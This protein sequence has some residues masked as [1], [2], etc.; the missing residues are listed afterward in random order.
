MLSLEEYEKYKEN[1]QQEK[2]YDIQSL[3]SVGETIQYQE[4]Q[5]NMD[6]ALNLGK[7]VYNGFMSVPRGVLRGVQWLRDMNEAQLNEDHPERMQ[8]DEG[9]R[10]LLDNAADA[11]MFQPYKVQAE[12]GAGQFVYDLAQGAGQLAGQVAV[13]VATGGYGTLPAM[14]LQ[15]G[16]EEYKELRDQGVDVSTAGKAA[17]INAAVQTPLEY[18]GFSKITKAFP[19]NS[20]FRQRLRLAAENVLTE[21]V[22]EFLQEYPEQASKLWALNADKS[23]EEIRQIIKDNLENMTADALYSGVIG[24]FLGGGAGALHMALDQN[25]T[26]AME[27]EVHSMRM[28]EEMN[29]IE[30][31]KESKINPPYAAAVINGNT[32]DT[33]VYVDGEALQGYAQEQGAEKVAEALGVTVEDIQTAAAN[34]DTVD[35]KLGNFEATAASFDGFFDAVKDDTAFED[36]GYTINKDKREQEMARKYQ[37]QEDAIRV[38]KDRIA[39]EMK[40][41][42]VDSQTIVNALAL[43]TARA[44]NTDDPV[45]LLRKLKFQSG[46]AAGQNNYH[47]FA[48]ENANTADRVKLAE[49]QRMEDGGASAED[50]FNTTGWLKG[51]DGKWRFEI[52]DNVED[53]DFDA[54]EKYGEMQLVRVYY[55]EKLFDAYPFLRR[56]NIK[57][58]DELQNDADGQVNPGAQEILLNRAKL[59]GDE[60]PF[61]LIHEIQHLIQDEEGFASGGNLDTTASF[62]EYERLGGEQ[63]ARE[64][65][66]RADLKNYDTMPEPHKSDAIIVF[67]G[68]E[69]PY[70]EKTSE[71]TSEIFK[72]ADS[73]YEGYIEQ[74]PD[75]AEDE[76][77]SGLLHEAFQMTLDFGADPETDLIVEGQTSLF[78]EDGTPIEQEGKAKKKRTD[79]EAKRGKIL[80]LGITRQLVNE[81][82]VSLVGKKVRSTRDLAEIAQVLRHPGYEKFHVVYVD[83]NNEVV[84][85][86]TISSR[87]PGQTSVIANNEDWSAAWR[88]IFE[89]RDRHHAEKFYFIHNH[90]SGDPRPSS[91]DMALTKNFIEGDKR[92][93]RDY[94]PMY[95]RGFA[96]HIIIDHNR[97]SVIDRNGKVRGEHIEKDQ[98]PSYDVAEIPH[99]ALYKGDE[100][101]KGASA[102]EIQ[103]RLKENQ[104]R[105]IN[106]PN[107]LD[108]IINMT[109]SDAETTAFFLTQ[110]HTVR[111]IQKLH[112]NFGDLS[113]P[114]M[115]RYLRYCARATA[116]AK[117]AIATSNY[118]VFNKIRDIIQGTPEEGILDAVYMKDNRPVVHA[119]DDDTAQHDLTRETWLGRPLGKTGERLLETN[120]DYAQG[121]KGGYNPETNVITLFQG[122]DAST[123]IHETWHF[124]V[125]QMW[126]SVQDG[127]ASEQ[128]VKDFDA[129]LNYAG[130]T[131]EEWA[132]AD[133]DGR[134]A[135]HER[136]AEA[137]ETYIMEG[138]SPSYDLRRV[139]R[140]FSRWLRN[141]YR[142]IQRNENAVPL[143]DEV[144]EVFDRMLAAEDDIARMERVNGYFEK[145]PDVI[146]EN[147]SDATRARVEDYIEK[148]RDKAVDL[149]TR[150]ALRN[151]TKQ[152]REDIKTIR[153]ELLPQVEEEVGNRRVYQCGVDKNDVK[154]YRKLKEK[155]TGRPTPE[156]FINRAFRNPSRND[157]A[158]LA[159]LVNPDNWTAGLSEVKVHYQQKVDALLQPA[160]DTLAKGMGQ[161]VDIVPLED[162]S[163]RG[164][165]VSN[166]APWYREF[167]AEHKR[168]PNKSELREMAR[169][170]V[171]GD[172]NA[173]QVEGWTPRSAEEAEA[174][175]KSGEQLAEFERRIQATDA[176]REKLA[177][178]EKKYKE[179][180]AQGGTPLKEDEA[181]F[182]LQTDLTAEQYGYS[183]TDEMLKD[184]ENSPTKRQAV[185]QRLD[186]LI[187]DLTEGEDRASHEEA[188]REAIYNGD[189]ALLIGVEQQLIEDYARK[190][191]GSQEQAKISAE[192][193]A[194]RRQQAKNAA[195]AD[196]AQMNVK[197]ATR[198]NK[199]ITAERKAAVK[200]AQLL[201]KKDFDGALVQKNMQAYWHAMAAE[202]MKV[203]KR[204]AQYD[205]FLKAQRKAKP[206][207]W[208][209]DL[210]FGAVSRLFVRMGIAREIHQQA[211]QNSEIQSL[212]AYAE[213]MEQQFDCVDIAEWL[214]D[215]NF[216]ISDTNALT[217]EQYEDVVNAVKNIKAIVKAQKGVNM[218]S[219]KESFADLKTKMLGLLAEL[220][221]RFT[222]NP[223]KP[224]RANTMERW[225]AA[226]E[227]TDTLFEMLDDS[228]YGFFSKTWGN[229]IKHASDREFDCLEKYNKAD[230]DALKK[231]LPDKAAEA[232]ANE[233]I[234][235]EDLGASVTK[236]VLV[237]MLINLG[238]A[239]NAQRLCETVPVGFE[240]SK[241]WIVPDES[242]ALNRKEANAQRKEAAEMTRKNLVDFF[243]RVLTPA[244]V[245][246]A[247]RKIDAAEMFW[248]EKNEME[249]RVK[250]FGLKKV[251]AT[252]VMLEIGGKQVVMKGGYF[253]LMRNGETGSHAAAAE[254]ADDDPLQGK[255]IRTYHTNTSATKARTKARYPV[256]LFPGAETQWIYESIHDLCWRE[257][258]NDFR[259]V[260]ND[261]EL[262]ATLKSKMGVAR[263]NNFK[264]LLEVS[265]DPQ[266]SKSFSEGERA[267][268]EAASWL[269][270]RTSHAII[271]CNLKVVAQNY[272]NAFLYGNAVDGY[273]MADNIRALG[274]YMLKY[275]T[276]GSHK[277]MVDFVKSKSSFMRERSELPDITVR[278]IVGENKEFAW[279]KV[280]REIGIQ[281]MAFTDNATAMPNWLEA[282]NKKLNEGATEQ[283]AIDFADAIVRRVLGSSRITDVASMQRGGPLMKLITM[284]QSFFNARW[285][286]F[287]RTER[288]VAKEWTKGEK[289]KAFVTAFSYVVS[290]WLGQ[291]MLAM[292]LALQNPFGVDDKDEWPELIKELKSYSFSMMGPV[293]QAGSYVIGKAFGMHEFDYR[294]SAVESTL[295]KIGRAAS[296]VG[297]DKATTQDKVEG[298]TDAAGLLI[299]VP[300]QFNRIFWNLFDAAVNDMDLQWGDVL[301][302]RPK[303]DRK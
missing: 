175:K 86:S 273:T 158:N 123:V 7:S 295:E 79:K 87:L 116:G 173:P 181:A 118:D 69:M 207:A 138:K 192:I 186:E 77:V 249:K 232:A 254:V 234:Y 46:T 265:A 170:M 223:N 65:A 169:L 269:R 256:N 218:F 142:T 298:I 15:I 191:K 296:K 51:K 37:E 259:R 31:I 209:N 94:K 168:K 243:S 61:T 144:R 80:G 34:N 125:E 90:P 119:F 14:A 71:T 250:G 10:Q 161:G 48:G 220:P 206:E 82:V 75:V 229:A 33:T 272:A 159:A 145:L 35:V 235:Y 72:E 117:C 130:M 108:A 140:N 96:G 292:A 264:E 174:L 47:Q 230:A 115:L 21:G 26:R 275:H 95:K 17:A 291:T 139:F 133:V 262:F 67:D 156:S 257:V 214:F 18:I 149:L 242:Q 83:A 28:D 221:T 187:N 277:E 53:V 282:Y 252:P 203:K 279:E 278:D 193:A 109:A 136:L 196:L 215:E 132:A 171:S 172:A 22:T 180:A 194:A 219:Q 179:R 241:L 124:F 182:V 146:T 270:Q 63:E 2:V 210:H 289:Q 260:I 151:Y 294:M 45:G 157:V 300:A 49:A 164:A 129:L 66:D 134:R 286:E 224:T 12:T 227:S 103:A 11:S 131:R 228:T 84:F 29:R 30:Q 244:D 202:S 73:L 155:E 236:H 226:M 199:F 153:A 271:I 128:T 212:A 25:I 148:A 284:F 201:A 98:V 89:D 114:A 85:H 143:T 122:A 281:A 293:G 76:K 56:V 176:I 251:E 248:G 81:G 217:L 42:G 113:A 268:G 288:V 141:V 255:R 163:G 184:V 32:Q 213:L 44:L 200:S 52:P 13:G 9:A 5:S 54:L 285:N 266:N 267:L 302:R 57:L 216:D 58:A 185:T 40:A 147:M 104:E 211:A 162:G 110:K 55:N 150:N 20:M 276:P 93:A 246:Y 99:K 105:K 283:E 3:L 50:I 195:K 263:M 290:K 112:D 225:Q 167:Y 231:W 60:M 4:Q 107:T 247:Q 190:A 183:S 70:S 62:D 41:A 36:G 233:E 154:H 258:M 16:G 64:T 299:G 239:D 137:G 19:A 88:R 102:E 237:K 43:A 97:Y 1:H 152:R 24:G 135:A 297:S 303:K 106:H 188:I 166:N 253:P 68:K 39:G 301:R 208:L 126:N 178:V 222:P 238:N 92:Y 245:E 287:L 74:H 23:P 165:R 78:D 127:S 189:Q 111:A 261:Q 274:R 280:S 38:E 6:R 205:K 197:D 120:A 121:Q 8:M 27:R 91:A 101:L 198:T 160:L 204:K 240:K 59:R 100:G 177:E